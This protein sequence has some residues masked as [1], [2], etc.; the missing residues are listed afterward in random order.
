MYSDDQAAA[1][2]NVLNP[3][4]ASD[5]YYLA[6]AMAA[7]SVL[8]VG[9][10][11]GTMLHRAR[12]AGHTGRLAGVDPDQAMLA[13]ARQRDD[14]DWGTC[15]AAEMTWDAE[16]DLAVMMSHAFQNFITNDDLRASL[17]AIYRALVDG[18]RF[19]FETRNPA[20]REWEQWHP[21]NPMD[22][23]NPA[24]RALRISYEV[25]SVV[26]DVVTLTETT[27][28]PDGP[29]LRVD[30]GKLRFLDEETLVRELEAAGFVIEAIHGGW[31]GEAFGPTSA[32]IVVTA[33]KA[34]AAG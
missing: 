34:V 26:G 23:V 19:A 32:E 17:A 9:C 11:T 14:I 15:T 18:G 13:I 2:Y 20:V 33:R 5:A 12:E 8:D 31:A 6:L 22:V 10:G 3:W 29:V 24:G 25:L 16:F 28:D 27:S 4:G 30:E 7:P 21:G 1:L